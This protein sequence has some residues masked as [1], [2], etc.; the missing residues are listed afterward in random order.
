M[1]GDD[2]VERADGGRWC[3][4]REKRKILLSEREVNNEFDSTQNILTYQMIHSQRQ[5]AGATTGF[6]L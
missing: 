1:G 4:V 3:L 5:F 2:V 6:G